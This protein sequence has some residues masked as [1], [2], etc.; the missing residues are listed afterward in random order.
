MGVAR[1][2]RQRFER[3]N[4]IALGLA[5]L[6]FTALGLLWWRDRARHY[7]TPRFDATRFV[8][9]LPAEPLAGRERWL[10]A[11]NLDCPHCQAHL[12]A[13]AARTATR[14]HPP[15]LAV[16]VVDQASRPSA[17][18]LGVP[19]A[20]GAW[21]DRAQVWREVWGR[22]VYGETFRFDEL[23]RLLSSTP[24]GVVPDSSGSRM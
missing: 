4:A 1:V 15:A 6:L 20:G 23:G 7:E 16:L 18:H 2:S 3:V 9:L 19:L 8:T 21:W 13:I 11:V 17:L 24:V 5:L 10:V 14:A 12:R 22:R